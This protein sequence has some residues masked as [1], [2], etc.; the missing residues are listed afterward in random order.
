MTIKTHKNIV[1]ICRCL[2]NTK[3]NIIFAAVIR[4]LICGENI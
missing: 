3:K 2:P 4:Y 1:K